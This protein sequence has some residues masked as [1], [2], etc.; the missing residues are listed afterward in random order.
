MPLDKLDHCSIRTL[1]LAETKD[2]F[3]ALGLRDGAR[4]PFD[5]PGHWLY[6]GEDPVVHLVG[7][8]PDNPD[9]LYDYLGKEDL[10]FPEGGGAVDHVAFR[11]SDPEALKKILGQR[12]IE[13]RER[14]VPDLKLFQIF[15]EDPNGVT[16]EIN[17]WES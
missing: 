11:A 6:A 3:E 17:Y 15:A 10:E 12:G 8:D 13:Y 9:G 5:F 14:V 16:V 7:I 1:K 4:P 2:F